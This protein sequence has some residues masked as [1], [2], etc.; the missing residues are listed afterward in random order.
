MNIVRAVPV[1]AFLALTACASQIQTVEQ[2]D[3]SVDIV[4]VL[5]IRHTDVNTAIFNN[6]VG[7]IGLTAVILSSASDT[8]NSDRLREHMGEVDAIGNFQRYFAQAMEARGT[9][10]QWADPSVDY[11]ARRIDEEPIALR[12]DQYGLR[13]TYMRDQSGLPQLDLGLQFVGFAA[14]GIGEDSPYR[15]TVIANVRMVGAD[16]RTVMFQKAFH[17]N[18][19][20]AGEGAVTIDPDANHVYPGL[21][22]LNSADP[23]GLRMVIDDALRAIAYRIVEEL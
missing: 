21:D 1:V 9:T 23:E 5:S 22:E 6:P 2:T 10:L 7:Y 11:R 17:Y 19:I 3:Q 12:R 18:P 8:A 4:K 13:R 15:P 20:T 16:G 14:A